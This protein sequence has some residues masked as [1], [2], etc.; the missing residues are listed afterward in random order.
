MNPRVT[1]FVWLPSILVTRSPCSVTSRLQASGQSRGQVLGTTRAASTLTAPPSDGSGLLPPLAVEPGLPAPEGG[2][3]GVVGGVGL[4]GGDRDQALPDG[5]DVGHL[6]AQPP[7]AALLDP[8]V[9]AAARVEALGDGS[10]V[11]PPPLPR[12]AR[13]HAPPP[14][15]LHDA[16]CAL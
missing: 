13:A 9:R 7:V 15:S 8:V 10:F 6:V 12:D 3:H 4:E 14:G 2:E 1:G 11:L 5:V 16:R